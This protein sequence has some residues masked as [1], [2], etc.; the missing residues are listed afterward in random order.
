M[1]A[2]VEGIEKLTIP[3]WERPDKEMK[4]VI[5]SIGYVAGSVLRLSVMDQESREILKTVVQRD[6]EISIRPGPIFLNGN[7]PSAELG[8]GGW[9]ATS[10]VLMD[11][12]RFLNRQF[13]GKD[14]CA[15]VGLSA[16]TEEHSV[17]G[18]PCGGIWGERIHLPC[19]APECLQSFSPLLQEVEE[20][21]DEPEKEGLLDR[22]EESEE[23]QEEDEKEKEQED[24]VEEDSQADVQGD[25]REPEQGAADESDLESPFEKEC[26]ATLGGG[27]V[28]KKKPLQDTHDICGIC[29]ESDLGSAPAHVVG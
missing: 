26:I 7:S 21:S 5:V 11:G 24:E 28:W 2:G 17:C 9:R 15:E 3:L 29:M 4:P 22:K 14:G 8:S 13:C 25:G 10:V 20:E 27:S 16:C 23:K 6:V 12:D 1:D 19:L 18:H